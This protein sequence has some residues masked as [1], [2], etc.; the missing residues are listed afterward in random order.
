M[1]IITCLVFQSPGMW[2]SSF[3][4]VSDS[5]AAECLFEAGISE[6]N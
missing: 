6:K 2:Y 4:A 3:E 1:F 5:S